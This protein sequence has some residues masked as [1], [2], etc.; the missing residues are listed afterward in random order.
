M[1][2][3]FVIRQRGMVCR[4]GIVID[5][6]TGRRG[7]ISHFFVWWRRRMVGSMMGF[8][9]TLVCAC[10]RCSLVSCVGLTV[11]A[12]AE[13]FIVVDLITMTMGLAVNVI[14]LCDVW[15][16]VM[17]SNVYFVTVVLANVWLTV[18]RVVMTIMFA[19]IFGMLVGFW[20]VTMGLGVM[21]Y[22]MR[23]VNGL[24]GISVTITQVWE[25]VVLRTDWIHFLMLRRSVLLMSD[26]WC[27]GRSVPAVNHWLRLFVLILW[28]VL[29]LEVYRHWLLLGHIPRRLLIVMVH[30]SGAGLVNLWSC[31]CRVVCCR[32][33]L[34]LRIAP[35]TCHRGWMG[36]NEVLVIAL[37][38]SAHRGRCRVMRRDLVAAL[39]PVRFRGR[40][41]KG[42]VLEVALDGGSD[43]LNWLLVTH[44]WFERVLASRD[45]IC[46]RESS[47]VLVILLVILIGIS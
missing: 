45:V 22:L 33:I 47:A 2:G 6:M 24:V 14:V 42:H 5:F 31:W 8:A 36:I 44:V 7:M 11:G 21:D 37:N 41:D 4:R 46:I 38:M 43:V 18:D 15:C 30:D 3:D 16:V 19:V 32:H 25:R 17:R 13:G 28:L 23:V 1:V 35:H 40:C 12:G 34:E 9:V 20:M 26:R 29:S 27:L 39:G 10:V